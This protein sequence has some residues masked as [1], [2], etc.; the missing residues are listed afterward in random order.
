M[1]NRSYTAA[2]GEDGLLYH[3]DGRRVYLF[4]CPVCDKETVAAPSWAMLSGMNTGHGSCAG[5]GEFLHLEITPDLDGDSMIAI[6]WDDHCAR[7]GDAE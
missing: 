2:K 6:K 5:C 3:P 1:S 7:I 4:N